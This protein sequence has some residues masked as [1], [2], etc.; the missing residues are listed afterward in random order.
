MLQARAFP[1]RRTH[2]AQWQSLDDEILLVCLACRV[3][4]ARESAVEADPHFRAANL[5]LVG[6]DCA[7]FVHDL[8]SSAS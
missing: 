3:A 6:A 7:S 8:S 1:A 5:L 2:L 4:A